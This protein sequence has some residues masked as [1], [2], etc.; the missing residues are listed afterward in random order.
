MIM[1]DERGIVN[2]FTEAF[3]AIGNIIHFRL[4]PAPVIEFHIDSQEADYSQD[5]GELT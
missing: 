3:V 2:S 5:Y 4:K 1:S